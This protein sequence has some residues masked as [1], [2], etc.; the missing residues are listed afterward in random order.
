VPRTIKALERDDYLHDMQVVA[1]GS[2]V[3]GKVAVLVSGV[4]GK[5]AIIY[6]LFCFSYEPVRTTLVKALIHLCIIN[7]VRP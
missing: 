2:P 7:L 5:L 1:I 3:Q 6:K 4:H